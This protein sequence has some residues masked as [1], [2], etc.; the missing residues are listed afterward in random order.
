MTRRSPLAF[1][2]ITS[3]LSQSEVFRL[4]SIII[5]DSIDMHYHPPTPRF[6]NQWTINSLVMLMYPSVPRAVDVA[7]LL[8]VAEGPEAPKKCVKTVDCIEMVREF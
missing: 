8:Y 1:F 4:K 7:C 6:L 2:I 3:V 5:G